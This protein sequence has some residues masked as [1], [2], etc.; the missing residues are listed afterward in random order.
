MANGRLLLSTSTKQ[1]VMLL[2]SEKYSFRFSYCC[3]NFFVLHGFEKRNFV[4]IIPKMHNNLFIE[5]YGDVYKDFRFYVFNVCVYMAHLHLSERP[6]LDGRKRK[7]NKH[8]S[9]SFC[10][11]CFCSLEK[12][13]SRQTLKVHAKKD[14]V[15]TSC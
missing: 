10:I 13:I 14:K 5:I 2:K 7:A 4:I 6:H 1:G 9:H 3:F 8:S 12:T 11:G 15:H